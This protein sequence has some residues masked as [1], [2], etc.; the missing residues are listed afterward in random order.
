[1]ESNPGDKSSSFLVSFNEPFLKVKLNS[2]L[3]TEVSKEFQIQEVF[4]Q[5]GFSRQKMT[6]LKKSILIIFEDALDSKLIEPR[7]TLLMKTNKTKEVEK[8]TSNLLVKAKSIF[9][10]EIP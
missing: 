1:L 6:R 10:T 3:T 5:A 9:Y 7:F 4:D 2:F 8:L